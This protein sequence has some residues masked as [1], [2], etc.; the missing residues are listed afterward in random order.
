MAL[1][2]PTVAPTRWFWMGTACRWIV[3]HRS[4]IWAYFDQRNPSQAPDYNWW[5]LMH[6]IDEIMKTGDIFFTA[7]Q[8]KNTLIAAQVNRIK[9][10]S[11]KLQ[12]L[13]LCSE[14]N[15]PIF[16]HLNSKLFS[17][18]KRYGYGYIVPIRIGLMISAWPDKKPLV[19]A[20]LGP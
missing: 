11:C 4:E 10:C 17:I 12:L 13:V 1:K 19:L 5:I 2:C 8:R 15:G 9:A 6:V 18:S 14:I 7:L 20:C 3:G 16:S